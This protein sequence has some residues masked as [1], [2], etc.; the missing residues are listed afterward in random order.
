MDSTEHVPDLSEEEK[1]FIVCASAVVLLAVA[2]AC[3]HARV[4]CKHPYRSIFRFLR[5]R[6]HVTAGS[7]CL[8]KQVCAEKAIL[9]RKFSQYAAAMSTFGVISIMYNILLRMPRWM[10]GPTIW[11]LL[12]NAVISIAMT[13]LPTRY[14]STSLDLL[15]IAWYLL[16]GFW[17]S[18]WT[19][20]MENLFAMNFI[21]FVAI[22][23]P[24]STFAK[25][26]A[27]VFFCQVGVLVLVVLRL[28]QEDMPATAGSIA[29]PRT[30]VYTNL[31]FI[32]C[33]ALVHFLSNS[34]LCQHVELKILFHDNQTELN[35]ASSLLELTCDAVVHLD[36]DFR[37][38]DDSPQLAAILFRRAETLRGTK[39]TDLIAAGEA[40]SAA[41]DLWAGSRAEAP[42]HAF[43]T[44]LVDGCSSK[45]RTEIFQVKYTKM[46]GQK[47]HLLGL[48]DFTDDKPLALNS[49]EMAAAEAARVPRQV[50]AVSDRSEVPSYEM[51]SLT[52]NTEESYQD[53]QPSQPNNRVL[54]NGIAE[55]C[56]QI[57]KKSVFLDINVDEKIVSAASAPFS[58]NLVGRSLCE[59][60]PH[61]FTGEIMHRLCDEAR[62]FA[63][64][65]PNAELPDQ[66]AAFE[67]MPLFVAPRHLEISGMMKVM[68]RDTGHLHVILSFAPPVSSQ[69]STLPGTQLAL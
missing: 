16:M 55:Q 66:V 68:L 58:A 26:C 14:L 2:V 33:G 15:C 1:S 59:I 41:E 50:F 7:R 51:G 38:K 27:V 65:E 18:P 9:A 20:S 63:K 10:N 52:L 35:A 67:G 24:V 40:Q 69:G 45:F 36:S 54:S 57:S 23:I 12:C 37:I 48:R 21:S 49:P 34:A 6:H 47:C 39:F 22:A 19:I 60:F 62:A 13:Q 28:V 17:Q 3:Y 11:G 44:H 31:F 61:A 42:A 32:G 53:L 46:N 56:L 43:H 5:R 29:N 64:Q 4:Y 30:L 25:H 8:A